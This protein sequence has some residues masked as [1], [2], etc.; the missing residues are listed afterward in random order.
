MSKGL[1]DCSVEVLLCYSAC[2]ADSFKLSLRGLADVSM[3]PTGGCRAVRMAGWVGA[4]AVG[5]HGFVGAA[6][7][8]LSLVPVRTITA[9]H[10]AGYSRAAGSV[11]VSLAAWVMSLYSWMF[12][13]FF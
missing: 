12:V 7:P 3:S 2:T 5:T 9:L 8:I 10:T 4:M 11:A 1:F 13:D 6:F